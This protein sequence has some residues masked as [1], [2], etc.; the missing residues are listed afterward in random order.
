MARFH[1]FRWFLAFLLLSLGLAAGGLAWLA[2][3]ESGLQTTG[4]LLASVTDGQLSLGGL[5]GRLLGPLSVD[6]LR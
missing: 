4:R 6:E 2:S 3:S 5:K 1:Y